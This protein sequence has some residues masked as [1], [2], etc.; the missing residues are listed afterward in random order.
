MELDHIREEL[1]A[2]PLDDDVRA[3]AF[4]VVEWLEKLTEDSAQF[5]TVRRVIDRLDL[6]TEHT[7]V[8]SAL[9]VLTQLSKPALSRGI[10]W[11]DDDG[12]IRELEAELY[13]E[14]LET[15]KLAHPDFGT[16]HSDFLKWVHP[17]FWM[18]RESDRAKGK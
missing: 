6:T 3:M 16:E 10:Y 14:A 1:T 12:N 15:G 8:L 9:Y 4:K 17:F 18:P 11:T 5:I 2:T 13:A 7:H